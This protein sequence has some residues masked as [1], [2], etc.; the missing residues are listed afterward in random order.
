MKTKYVKQINNMPKS[1]SSILVIG[2]RASA[3]TLGTGGQRAE[4][5]TEGRK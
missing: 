2:G 1:G 3:R 5:G 4:R